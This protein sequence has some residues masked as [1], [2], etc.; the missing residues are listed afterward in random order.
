M[1]IPKSKPAL[2]WYPLANLIYKALMEAVVEEFQGHLDFWLSF[3]DESSAEER[4]C[5]DI[6]ST[7]DYI[8]R[9]QISLWQDGVSFSW[10]NERTGGDQYSFD[11]DGGYLHSPE[12]WGT[13]PKLED[14]FKSWFEDSNSIY[15]RGIILLLNA[16]P[17]SVFR[18]E[19]DLS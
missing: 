17:R 13:S 4:G 16:N 19:M 6:F 9:I 1:K 8:E 3:A 10:A 18:H 7:T 11:M 12:E 2:D 15:E 5:A 14:S